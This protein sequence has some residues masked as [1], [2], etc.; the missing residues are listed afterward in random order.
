[1][2][3]LKELPHNFCDTTINSFSK[4]E[5][6]LIYYTFIWVLFLYWIAVMVTV[7]LF[8]YFF[9]N[10][11]LKSLIGYKDFLIL[12]ASQLWFTYSM[13][14]PIFFNFVSIL[15]LATN[16]VIKT[17]LFI[18]I[19]NGY[20]ILIFFYFCLLRCFSLLLVVFVRCTVAV[21]LIKKKDHLSLSQKTSRSLLNKK[22]KKKKEKKTWK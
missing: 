19:F 22:A 9:F 11:I 8:L 3:T 5:I 10:F 17:I 18:F 4:C 20:G 2:V 15:T 1:M 14:P 13:H 6:I 7:F 16:T 21:L 12:P